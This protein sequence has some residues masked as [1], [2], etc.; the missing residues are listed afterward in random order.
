MRKPVRIVFWM[1]SIFIVL[2]MVCLG[3]LLAWC[4]YADK[5]NG[6]IISSGVARRY[7]LY[8]PR[9]YDRS[10]PAPL[11]ISIHPAAT[12]PALQAEISQ[13]NTVADVHG[14]IVVYPAGSG[15]FFGGFGRGPH[16]WPG[17]ELFARDAKFLSQLIDQ[18]GAQ[19][20]IDRSRIYVNGMSNG[21]TMSLA[22]PC[23]LR[24]RIAAVGAVAPALPVGPGEDE[25]EKYSP[26]PTIIFHG[27][28]DKMAPYRGGK[29][30]IVPRPF[31][32]IP[33]WVAK[34]A[35]ANQCQAPP[36]ETSVS[37]AVVR[38]SYGDCSSNADVVFYTIRD[39]GHTW[40]GGKHLAEW[41]A[42]K[43][44]DEI[45]ASELMWDF[46]AQHPRK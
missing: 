35:R 32:N 31:P 20:N 14:F 24:D 29:S 42:G 2:P 16:V 18:L 17:E 21:G 44:T 43:T 28:A 10:R 46:F 41:I 23:G 9:T 6:T 11:V 15:A 19:Y 39:G 25:C 12:W 45:N 1:V 7:L 13:W 4:S 27:T 34:V 3:G 22:L 37:A 33:D 26:V 8:V 40:P 38:R 36:T 5:T 30:P